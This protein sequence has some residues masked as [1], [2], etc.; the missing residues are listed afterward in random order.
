MLPV[1][2]PTE[3]AFSRKVPKPYILDLV[4]SILY[5]KNHKLQKTYNPTLSGTCPTNIGVI[6]RNI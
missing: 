4:V 3:T 6:R 5:P 2:L 1:S